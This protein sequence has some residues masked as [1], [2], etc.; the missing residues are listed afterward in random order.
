[1]DKDGDGSVEVEEFLAMS[2][3]VLKQFI[4]I[5]KDGNGELDFEEFVAGAPLLGMTE[6]ESTRWFEKLD[7]DHSGVITMEE[8]LG[9]GLYLHQKRATAD[10]RAVFKKIDKSG[11]GVLR[12][13]EFAKGARLLGLSEFEAR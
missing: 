3:G 6:E 1:M 7:S 10:A 13:H 9:V 12:L 11:R 2:T 4:Q 8:F 5:D